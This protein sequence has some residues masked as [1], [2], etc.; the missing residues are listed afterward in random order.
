MGRGNFTKE[1]MEI[2]LRNPYV[3]DVNE[4]AFRILP[5]SNLI[6]RKNI[7]RESVRRRS[8]ATLGR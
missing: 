2:L 1:E 6:W 4:K 3:S 7:S 5:N 8:S